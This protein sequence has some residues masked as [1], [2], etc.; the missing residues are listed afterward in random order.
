MEA[1]DPEGADDG[2]KL[3]EPED[4]WDWVARVMVGFSTWVDL[5]P[6]KQGVVDA[7]IASLL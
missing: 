1:D 4:D 6:V 2:F 5:E 7:C 3:P